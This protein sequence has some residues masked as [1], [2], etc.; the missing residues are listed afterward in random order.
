MPLLL[1]TG[2][3]EISELYK[4]ETDLYYIKV[5]IRADEHPED[6]MTVEFVLHNLTGSSHPV[7]HICEADP[8]NCSS[9][10]AKTFNKPDEI[11]LV[12][13][14]ESFNG[15][16]STQYKVNL[17]TSDFSVLPE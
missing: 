13:F 14:S 6:I 11:R 5:F 8:V 17:N 12:N 9:N 10:L 2:V 16:N 3:S 15:R 4:D 7:F 1:F